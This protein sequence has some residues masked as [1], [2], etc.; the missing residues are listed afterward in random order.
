MSKPKETCFHIL[1]YEKGL[2]YYLQNYFSEYS[3]QQI[4]CDAS[5][6]NM[7]FSELTAAKIHRDFPECK[8]LVILRDPIERAYS[9]YRSAANAGLETLSFEKAFDAE[10]Y[11]LKNDQWPL[12]ERMYFKRGMYY[13]QI[14]RYLDYFDQKNIK[15]VIY[16]EFF[17]DPHEGIRNILKFL[18]LPEYFKIDV[19][20]AYNKNQ[21]QVRNI[22]LQRFLR[23]A[24]KL[25]QLLKKY[26]RTV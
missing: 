4:V 7:Y 22:Y 14:Q 15:F 25:E 10:D 8:L 20:K 19:I 17:S 21:W 12:H 24:I 11:R 18:E 9:D 23:P 16:E 13:I 1:G 5:I 26:C 3:G 2:K 6:M